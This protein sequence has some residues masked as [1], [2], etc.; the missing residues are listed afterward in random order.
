ML[1]PPASVDLDLLPRV[2]HELERERD[3]PRRE[4]DLDAR[5]ELHEERLE[6]ECSS[7]SSEDEPAR[8]RPR[9]GERAG[10]AVRVPAELVRD[11]EDPPT[12]VVGDARPAVECVRDCAFRHARTL[13]DVPDRDS[14]RSLLGHSDCSFLTRAVARMWAF[15]GS[16]KSLHRAG[17]DE[18]PTRA[19]PRRRRAA[20][21][22]ARGAARRGAARSRTR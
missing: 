3:G 13:C 4:L 12:G 10:G 6:R 14:A 20:R 11:R 5:D 1:A 18:A 16:V 2:L 17:Y 7:R 15:T 21:R 8:V 22:C 9:C 19:R